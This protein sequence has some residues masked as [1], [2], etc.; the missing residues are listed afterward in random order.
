MKH[1]L[2][3]IA[4]FTSILSY[5]QSAWVEQASTGLDLSP[6]YF[7]S[8][9]TGFAGGGSGSVLR[10]FNGGETWEDATNGISG[11]VNYIME[12]KFLSNDTGFVYGW[13]HTYLTY[14]AGTTWQQYGPTQAFHYWTMD[15]WDLDHVC[16]AGRWQS[17]WDPNNDVHSTRTG[18]DGWQGSLIPGSL[19]S[20]QHNKLEYLSMDTIRI[21]SFLGWSSSNDGGLTWGYET[22]MN[23]IRELQDNKCSTEEI[24][25]AL[26]THGEE[27]ERRITKG[28]ADQAKE[29]EKKRNMEAEECLAKLKKKH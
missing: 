1:L 7:C 27:E 14:D 25:S 12:F 22:W 6:V 16:I 26:M 18:P 21:A 19:Y 8:P 15:A 9:D 11:N 29:N 10:T 24:V 20:W 13:G 4:I 3:F 28:L 2:F 23:L 17:G 5:S